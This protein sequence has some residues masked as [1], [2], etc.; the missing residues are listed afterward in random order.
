MKQNKTICIEYELIDKLKRED[1]ASELISN[2]L[3]QHYSS[4]TKEDRELSLKQEL[5][6]LQSVKEEYDKLQK[7]KQDL[8]ANKLA[9][10][11]LREQMEKDNEEYRRKMKEGLGL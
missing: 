8:E 4:E 7:E 5:A 1:N 11:E 10:K 3:Y 9:E 6:K 2:L